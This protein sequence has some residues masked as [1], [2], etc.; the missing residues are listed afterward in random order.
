[1][2][3]PV[4]GELKVAL[5]A[6]PRVSPVIVVSSNRKPWSES[7]F[8]NAWWK[9]TAKAGIKDLTFHDLRGTAVV[10][11]ARAGCTVP[12]ICSHHRP[13]AERRPGDPGQALF[14]A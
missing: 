6:A 10:R 1:V 3:V 9:A 7:G 4:S 14:A 8:Q 11:R 12:E 5:D 2:A 13:Q